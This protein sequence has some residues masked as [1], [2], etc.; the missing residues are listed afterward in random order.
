MEACHCTAVMIMTGPI[1]PPWLEQAFAADPAAK[2]PCQRRRIWVSV[3]QIWL[4][5]KITGAALKQHGCVARPCCGHSDPDLWLGRRSL[6]ISNVGV[7]EAFH[8]QELE[9]RQLQREGSRCRCFTR[10]HFITIRNK[11]FLNKVTATCKKHNY[12]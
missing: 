12:K 10:G 7:A 9:R 5:I 11:H 2:H 6:C 1:S 3:S 8:V 4:H